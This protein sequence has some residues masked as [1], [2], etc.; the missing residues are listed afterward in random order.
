ME[1]EIKYKFLVKYI[2]DKIENDDY[3]DRNELKKIL[4]ALDV[5][6]DEKEIEPNE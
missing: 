2:K 3:L 5:E 1:Y 4:I 6:I